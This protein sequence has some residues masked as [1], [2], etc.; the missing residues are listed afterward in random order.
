MLAKPRGAALFRSCASP[1]AWIRIRNGALSDDAP[2][3]ERISVLLDLSGLPVAP[4]AALFAACAAAIALAG[5]RLAH[6][7]DE[8][9][10]RTG[11]GE[12]VAGA[13]FVGGS[14]SLP[15][16]ITSMTTAAEGHAGL[17]IGNAVGGL[18]A[19]TSFLAIADLAYRRVNLEHAA[20]SVTGLAQATLLVTML[21]IPLIAASTPEVTILHVHPAS[22]VLFAMYG[23]GLRLLVRIK[24]EPMWSPVPT[25]D[26]PREDAQAGPTPASR[27]STP[28]LWRSFAAMAGVTAVAG[29]IVGEASIAL[30]AA[31]GL[32]ETAVGTVFTALA[33]SLPELVTAVAA[34]RIGAVNLA[35][36][37]IIGGNAFE[38]L[39]LAA[40]D[41]FYTSG[42]IYH[43]F[44]AD[45]VTVTLLAILMT[46][47][48]LLGMLRRERRGIANI[49]W[50]SAL[51]LALYVAS[52][53]LV[54]A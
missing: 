25:R 29:Y 19:Q 41:L 40:G 36:G 8:L 2:D 31:T 46:G 12:I 11:M 22:I 17:A 47:V 30:V 13:L 38:V 6:I 5:T 3:A 37:D 43:R 26:T 20:A 53:A 50:E 16:I 24:A 28:Q 4:A 34:V 21:T 48:L 1:L 52:V 39:F 32:S 15:G 9:A 7:A 23:F 54:L 42:S 10:E 45:N 44:T 33:N 35:V 51:V 49:G 18:T 27:R 14:T